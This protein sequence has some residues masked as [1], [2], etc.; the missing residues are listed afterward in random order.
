MKDIGSYFMYVCPKCGKVYNSEVYKRMSCLHCG[1]VVVYTGYR[2]G[3]WESLSAEEKEKVLGEVKK[4]PI[5]LMDEAKRS[6]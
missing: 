2:K 4:T 5:Q 1:T 3:V 6:V